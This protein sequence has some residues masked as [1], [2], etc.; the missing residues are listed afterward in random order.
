M[1]GIEV[2]TAKLNDAKQ[3]FVGFLNRLEG[4]LCTLE[5]VERLRRVCEAIPNRST[6]VHGDCHPGNVM[7][8]DGRLV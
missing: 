6:F 7:I 3:V 1:H 5:E 8:H 2:D 4:H